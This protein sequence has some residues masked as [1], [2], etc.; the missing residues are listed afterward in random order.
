MT[1]LIIVSLMALLALYWLSVWLRI[2]RQTTEVGIDR[3][4]RTLNTAREAG[5]EAR[6]PLKSAYPLSSSMVKEVARMDGWRYIG[7]GSSEGVS[8]L[9]FTLRET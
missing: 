1:T 3:V 9:R 8:K 2:L 5:V 7:G 4:Q 6:V